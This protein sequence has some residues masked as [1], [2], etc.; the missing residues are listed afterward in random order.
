[1]QITVPEELTALMSAVAQEKQKHSSCQGKNV[2]SFEQ[3]ARNALFFIYN[4]YLTIH[5][6]RYQYLLISLH[7][8][9]VTLNPGEIVLTYIRFSSNPCLRDIGPRTRVWSE[10]EVVDQAAYEF[11]DVVLR[12]VRH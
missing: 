7:W 11:A 2:C 5:L 1:M 10:K 8:L 9:L 6:P 3:K 4:S 12:T